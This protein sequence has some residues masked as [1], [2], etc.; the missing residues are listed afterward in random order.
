MF[1]F[2]TGFVLILVSPL[3][4]NSGMPDGFNATPNETSAPYQCWEENLRL[5]RRQGICA[6]QWIPIM[7]HIANTLTLPPCVPCSGRL[8]RVEYVLI[9][10]L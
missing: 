1:V 2:E 4:L 6:C 3:C 5:F 10:E 9:T 7:Y 8:N